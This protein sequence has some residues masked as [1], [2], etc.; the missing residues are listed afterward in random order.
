MDLGYSVFGFENI[1]GSFALSLLC[2]LCS[3]EL[4]RDV[5]GQAFGLILNI[6]EMKMAEA[7][8][9]RARWRFA[10]STILLEPPERGSS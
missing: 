2:S 1:N 6:R 5:V 8:A 3:V 4:K 10:L 7:Q 9:G